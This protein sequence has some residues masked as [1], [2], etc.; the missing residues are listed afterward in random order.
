MKWDLNNLKVIRNQIFQS[1][2]NVTP[3]YENVLKVFDLDPVD[4][5]VVIL[6]QD[7]YHTKNVANGLAFAS[8]ISEYT[9]PSLKNI[10]SEIKSSFGAIN[11][12]NSLMSWQNQGVFLLNTSLTT[13]IGKPNA[14]AHLWKAEITKLIQKLALYNNQIIWVLWGNQAKDMQQFLP[15]DAIV[16]K[17]AHPSPFSFNLR[18][19]RSFKMIEKHLKIKW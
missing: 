6:G 8:N 9:P 16:I 12:D 19:H 14:H 5:K 13:V 1:F 10:F 17:D 11:T 4:I 3:D 2:Q 18:H 7:P 15:E